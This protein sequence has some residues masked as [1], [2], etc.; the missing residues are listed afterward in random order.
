MENQFC[1]Y[2]GSVEGREPAETK[3]ANAN[4]CYAQR[5]AAAV[6]GVHQSAYCLTAA[7][8]RCALNLSTAPLPAEAEEE[9]VSPGQAGQVRRRARAVWAWA[10]GAVALVAVLIVYGGDLLRPGAPAAPPPA[11][12]PASVAASETPAGTPVPASAPAAADAR[13]PGALAPDLPRRVARPTA[14]A[15]GSVVVLQPEAGGSGWWASGEGRSEHLD[16]SFLYA[17]VY[18]GQAMI[19]A[20]RFDLRRVRRARR[21][22]RRR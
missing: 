1:P 20:V 9:A 19:S 22:A 3:P 7:H 16:D 18:K 21:S 4:R 6:D 12:A 14:E 8:A 15:G 10:F 2:L 17:G 11:A 5:T 13:T